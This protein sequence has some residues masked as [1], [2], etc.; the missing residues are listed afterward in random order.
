MCF[1]KHVP[2]N[3]LIQRDMTGGYYSYFKD[4]ETE[5]QRD[6]WASLK[7]GRACGVRRGRGGR[8]VGVAGGKVCSLVEL[9][10]GLLGSFQPSSQ[11]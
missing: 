7:P 2:F 8:I 9:L 5:L 4:T 1:L 10:F 3:A 11:G 6:T